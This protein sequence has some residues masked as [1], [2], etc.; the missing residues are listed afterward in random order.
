MLSIEHS[1]GHKPKCLTI[2]YHTHI[3]T[4][5]TLIIIMNNYFIDCVKITVTS[6]VSY[7]S[8]NLYR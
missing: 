6:D 1:L 7:Q 5:L 3:H 8:F 4:V 2:I